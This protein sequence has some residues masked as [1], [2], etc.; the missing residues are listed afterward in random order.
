[1]SGHPAKHQGGI[2]NTERLSL[3][4]GNSLD[5][6]T[7]P[8]I[9]L[10]AFYIML[11]LNAHHTSSETCQNRW[12]AFLSK[13]LYGHWNIQTHIHALLDVLNGG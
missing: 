10:N 1:M 5:A 3:A 12:N 8:C 2:G 6:C 11:R 13:S 9:A 4:M 7:K